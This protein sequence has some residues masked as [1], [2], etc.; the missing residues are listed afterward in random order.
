MTWNPYNKG[1]NPIFLQ[2]Q[3]IVSLSAHVSVIDIEPGSLEGSKWKIH[4][5]QNLY[6][7]S[8]SGDQ[9]VNKLKNLTDK[10]FITQAFQGQDADSNAFVENCRIHETATALK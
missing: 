7:L 10:C 5:E 2:L 4:V 9:D 1:K 6:C 8:A 3:W